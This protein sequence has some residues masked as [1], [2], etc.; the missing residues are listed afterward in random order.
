MIT[1]ALSARTTERL[2][3]AHR[4]RHKNGYEPLYALVKALRAVGW[5]LISISDP[6]DVSR[7]IVRVWEKRALTMELP[8]VTVELPSVS[9]P[10]ATIEA[11]EA[12]ARR[13]VRDRREAALL[14]ANL[15]RLRELQP[16]AEALRGPSRF[17]P[18]LAEASLEYTQL[19]N[20]TV[21]AGVRVRILADA[22]GIQPITINARLRRSGLRKRAPSEREPQWARSDW[23]ANRGA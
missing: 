5:P 6:L 2:Q 19:I 7:E 4:N 3:D 17:S 10:K 20:S 11:E 12:A 14:A 13:S 9:I 1:P 16:A 22:L 15:P 23:S 18:E 8:S 21:R